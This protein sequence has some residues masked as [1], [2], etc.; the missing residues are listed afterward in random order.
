MRSPRRRSLE[1]TAS[2]LQVTGVASLAQHH[3]SLGGGTSPSQAG[4]QAGEHQAG[5][6]LVSQRS[7][8]RMSWAAGRHEPAPKPFGETPFLLGPAS[9]FIGGD[10]CM[11][12]LPAS[13]LCPGSTQAW[14]P[15]V[16]V[17]SRAHQSPTRS[18]HLGMGSW[19]HPCPSVLS[20]SPALSTRVPTCPGAMGTQVTGPTCTLGNCSQPGGFKW[21]LAT[22]DFFFP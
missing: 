3:P 18:G 5:A 11:G 17:T 7:P 22:F 12:L 19:T 20:S 4:R 14:E 16:S 13:P 9:C 2:S 6:P 8:P 15:A 1:P 10:S 21:G